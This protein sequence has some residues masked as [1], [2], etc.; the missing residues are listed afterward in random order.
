[1][2]V[3]LFLIQ[4]KELHF[5]CFSV[6]R[7]AISLDSYSTRQESFEGE[8]IYNSWLIIEMKLLCLEEQE[9]DFATMNT[10]TRIPITRIFL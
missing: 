1:M 6:F 7:P 10:I 8:T 3:D 2:P 4:L 5:F 9:I